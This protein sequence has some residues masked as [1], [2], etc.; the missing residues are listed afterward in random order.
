[1]SQNENIYEVPAVITG[2]NAPGTEPDIAPDTETP[3]GSEANPA[4]Q[5]PANP[6]QSAPQAAQD[7]DRRDEV[8]TILSASDI[9]LDTLEDEYVQNDGLKEESY[10]ALEKAG[11]S[12]KVVDTYIA[13]IEADNA[14]AVVMQEREVQAIKSMVGGEAQYATL[15]SWAM[16]NLS[17]E[18]ITGFNAIMETNNPTA[19]RM[20]VKGLNA[21]YHSVVGKDPKYLTGSAPG[22]LP[23]DTFRSWPEVQEAMNDKRYKEDPAYNRRVCE[24]LARSSL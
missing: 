23:L 10:A 3:P 4:P 18:E 15:Q 11:F 21:Q 19:I 16:K 1:M 6:D 2:P 17:E 22:S 7:T 13:G 8:R 5:V 24:K 12:R 20:A 14:K 9:K